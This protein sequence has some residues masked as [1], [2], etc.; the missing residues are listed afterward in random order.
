M[1]VRRLV[2]TTVEATRIL[3]AAAGPE[4]ALLVVL[5]L[6]GAVAL[7]GQLLLGKRLVDQLSDDAGDLLRQ[8]AWPLAGLAVCTIVAAGAVAVVAERQRFVMELVQRHLEERIIGVVVGVELEELDEPN[9]H[10]RLR[11]AIASYVNQ[12]YDLVNGVVGAVGACVGVLAIA[13]VLLP[14]SPWMLPLVLL[15]ALPLGWASTR[16]SRDLYRRYRELAKLD[17]QREHLTEVLTTPR[18][19]AEIRL[20]GAEH[21]LLPRYRKLY[22]ER[23]ATVRQLSRERSL[24]LV[25]VQVLVALFGVGVLAVLI[26][27]TARGHLT[28]AE[29]GL[30]AIAVQQLLQRLR[31]ASSSVG[32]MHEA[33]LFLG[34]LT[35]FLD[36]PTRPTTVS[37]ASTSRP[38]GGLALDSVHF[39]YPG[40]QREVVHDLSL[41]IGPGEVVALVGPNGAGKSTVAKLL[42]GLYAPTQGT[43]GHR[44]AA[45]VEPLERVDL[46][47]EVTAVF[48]DFARYAL[49]ARDNIALADYR[50][51]DDETALRKAAQEAGVA[52]I[53]ESLPYGYDTILSR[54]FEHGTD[55]SVGQWQRVALARA[56]FRTAPFLVLDEP[57]AAADAASER[58]FLDQLRATCAD[59]GV[60]LITHRLSTARRADRTY[61]MQEGRIVE[62][63]T[64]D[65]LSGAEGPYSELNRLHSGL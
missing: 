44:V 48:Q 60:L 62:S 16:N 50:R 65:E 43:I 40:T 7:A 52:H 11:R 6:L 32:S 12:P 41:H 19:A 59:R 45:G 61:V 49:T 35:S 37:R 39:T 27:L 24:R 18:P 13:V 15:A 36:T 58:A 46:R 10:D 8:V 53:I 2:A 64:H 26:G 33:S 22:D 29:A 34:D 54:A 28:V 3:R 30:A 21:Y 20:F 25:A 14:I 23:V 51:A 31:L 1:P 55:L 9:F 57:T 17:R 63:G 4:L 42:C 38:R 47:R 5:Q 56:L